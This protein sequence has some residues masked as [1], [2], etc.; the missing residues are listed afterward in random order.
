AGLIGF[1]LNELVLRTQLSAD[2]SFRALLRRVRQVT[3]G[4]YAH[5]H[6]PFARLVEVMRPARR[7]SQ[8]PLFQG[9]LTLPRPATHRL[10]LP[11]LVLT[12][13]EV[14]TGAARFDLGLD[15]VESAQGVH[16][17]CTYSADLFE[18]ET[19]ERLL[20]HYR[21][22]VGAVVADPD[23]PL[24]MLPLLT[25]ADRHRQLV[26]WNQ[27]RASYPPDRCLH[28]LVEAQAER[29][30]DAVAV[31]DASEQLTYRQLDERANQL[32][33]YLR[34]QGVG[35][36]VP[37]GLCVG[38]SAALV[39][40][41]LGILKAG[42]AYVPLDPAHPPERLRFQLADSRVP[43]L[44]T[45][46]ALGLPPGLLAGPVVRLDADGPSIAAEPTTRPPALAGPAQAAYVLYTS[47]ST[48]RPKGIV[49]EHRS[50]VNLLQAM[51]TLLGIGRTDRLLAITSIAFD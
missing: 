39:V 51:R 21:T 3:L 19:I 10:A 22:L 24:A 9:H 20:A 2:W 30:P 48:G 28:Q 17:T 29:T 35:S 44:V 33:R 11:G 13:S 49:V 34:L 23:Q 38:R 43:L 5:Q 45:E 6:L 14:D 40:G 25:E 36:E 50:V 47:G 27:T 41:S 16:G 1:F 37:V 18:A 12:M 8:T 31:V 4:A 42:G 32:A 7:W 26:E 46:T 15:L